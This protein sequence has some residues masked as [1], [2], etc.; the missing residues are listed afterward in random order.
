MTQCDLLVVAVR[1]LLLCEDIDQ[2]SCGDVLFHGI[3]NPPSKKYV[4]FVPPCTNWVLLSWLHN[5]VIIDS[6]NTDFTVVLW[7][8]AA[9]F[10]SYE[11]DEKRHSLSSIEAE[12]HCAATF[13]PVESAR[14]FISWN[15][16]SCVIPL[17]CGH[18]MLF[19]WLACLWDQCR[20]S[21]SIYWP[22]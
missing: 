16:M 6:N 9:V 19:A 10:P 21:T 15:F 17:P 14:Y 5:I 3:I 13:K 1:R 2:S 12:L 22:R 4:Q 18:C 8:S 11:N 20:Y 7:F